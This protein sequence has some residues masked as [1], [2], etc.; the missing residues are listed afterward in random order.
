MGFYYNILTIINIISVFGELCVVFVVML[1][2]RKKGLESTF[3]NRLSLA[4]NIR[5]KK[6]F[7][8]LLYFFMNLKR[9]KKKDFTI[10]NSI[11]L[12]ITIL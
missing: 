4:G 9:M 1:V 7:L 2:L 12:K 10:Y 8:S 6:L 3:N 5:Y 11:S